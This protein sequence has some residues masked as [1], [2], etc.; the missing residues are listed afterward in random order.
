MS[1]TYQDLL[2]YKKLSS[3]AMLAL[4]LAAC[5]RPAPESVAQTSAPWVRTA[6]PRPASTAGLTL[7]GTVRARHESPLAFQVG[8]RIA[9]R[10]VEA[11]QRIEAGRLLFELD[12]ADLQQA[13]HAAE[14]EVAAAQTALAIAQ[15]DAER[16][17]QLLQRNFISRQALERSELGVRETRTRFDAA[18]ARLQLA[19]NA[20]AY[21]GLRAASAGVL[22][23]TV[24]EPGQVVA[25]GQTVALLAHEGEREL[26]VFL[27]DGVPP[28]ASGRALSV[29]G[30]SVR[31]A[32][33]MTAGAAET[34]SRTWRARYRIEGEA[35]GLGSVL[36]VS[37]DAGQDPAA[38]LEVP[39]S[40]LDERGDGARVW[41]IVDGVAQPFAVEVLR[42]TPDAAQI[43]ATLPPDSRVIV[44]GTHLLQSGMAVREQA[45]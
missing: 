34:Q 39:L 10:R 23:E 21:G 13:L 43:R 30:R 28:P 25:P 36:R 26:E 45:Q 14:A 15:A 6:A 4:L 12:P 27:P 32:L 19:R 18:Q 20:L 37:F 42:L 7:T 11:G 3:V 1:K 16:N 17:R 29:D 44:L 38:R 40:A 24:A 2:M 41:R 8:G 31:L 9:A 22:I 33:R 5:S 35:P